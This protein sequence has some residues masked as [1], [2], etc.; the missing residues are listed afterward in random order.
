MVCNL[1]PRKCG[2][3]RNIKSGF[4]KAE[5][6][7]KAARASLH[8]WEEPPISGK[9]GS[10]TVFFSHCNLK[11]VF[12][13]NYKISSEGFGYTVDASRL[14]EIFLKLQSMGAENINLV[15]PTPYTY[16]II[17][18]LDL[19]RD[20]LNIP[21]VWNTGGYEN[22]ETLELLKDYVDIF[23]PD[24]KYVSNELAK[25]YSNAEDYPYYAH[26]ALEKM[27]SLVGKEEY[28]P[29]GMMK[30]GVIV[31][32]LILPSHKD[33][34]IKVLTHLKEYFGTEDYSLSLMRQYYPCYRAA[35]YPKIN[36][37][38]TTYEYDKVAEKAQELGFH[39][40]TQEKD[41]ADPAYTPEFDL[42]GIV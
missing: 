19:C 5:A 8:M 22:P 26:R 40:F 24:F 17:K 15:S 7:I 31:R 41:S 12:C 21:V 29:D 36:R 38:L 32:H 2:V 35:E 11:C 1:C 23:L 42:F 39:G 18:A 4:C 16:G 9:N 30:K 28:T 25:K 33:E 10:G 34:S 37:K 13:Q 6:D 20:K 27:L 3:D 14:C